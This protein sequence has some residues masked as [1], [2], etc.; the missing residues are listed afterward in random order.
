MDEPTEEERE[1]VRISLRVALGMA[2]TASPWSLLTGAE[3]G[4]RRRDEEQRRKDVLIG[5]M[6]ARIERSVIVRR[7][8]PDRPLGH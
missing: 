8:E 5:D 3:K 6:I 1:G 7:R 2:L 4:R